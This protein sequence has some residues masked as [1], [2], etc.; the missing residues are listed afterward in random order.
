MR[1]YALAEQHLPSSRSDIKAAT[2]P[3]AEQRFPEVHRLMA[4]AYKTYGQLDRE[5]MSA[6]DRLRCT[7]SELPA[8]ERRELEALAAGWFSA[9]E[10]LRIRVD[11]GMEVCDVLEGQTLWI[12]ERSATR[13]LSNFREA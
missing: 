2:E 12:S 8:E 3:T 7:A 5:G 11:E 4:L 13:L 9:F 10:I 1:L 6:V